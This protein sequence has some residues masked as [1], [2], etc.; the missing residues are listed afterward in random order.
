MSEFSS[1]LGF[2][3]CSKESGWDGDGVGAALL[4]IAFLEFLLGSKSAK[5]KVCVETRCRD[6]T[7]ADVLCLRSSCCHHHDH[8]HYRLP[9]SRHSLWLLEILTAAETRSRRQIEMI[10]ISWVS[11][12]S[13]S[14]S[15][16]RWPGAG[17]MNCGRQGADALWSLDQSEAWTGCWWPIRGRLRVLVWPEAGHGMPGMFP[18]P[19]AP[20]QPTILN[21]SLLSL[22]HTGPEPSS[23]NTKVKKGALTPKSSAKNTRY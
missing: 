2:K 1:S 16:V 3:T 11:H 22:L 9:L 17:V 23:G 13:V 5:S 7:A 12:N 14:L 20:P 6:L 21:I 10:Q 15:M 8:L 18:T 19:A 4:C